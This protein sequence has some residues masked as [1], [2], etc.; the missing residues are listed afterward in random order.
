MMRLAVPVPSEE[1]AALSLQPIAS[2]V[3]V[4][5]HNRVKG[6]VPFSERRHLVV[7]YLSLYGTG[8][9]PIWYEFWLSTGMD[10]NVS[11]GVIL[12]NFIFVSLL[13]K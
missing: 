11:N 9:V 13:E 8:T 6:F 7:P 3:T 2:W 1:L 4:S 10:E 5:D 12:I